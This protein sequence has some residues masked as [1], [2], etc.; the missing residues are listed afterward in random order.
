MKSSPSLLVADKKG[1]I[2]ER[3]GFAL[4]ADR[5]GRLF[6]PSWDEL[7]PLPAESELFYLPGRRATGLNRASGEIEELN[8]TAVAAFAAPGYTL[9]ATPAYA[10]DER[11]PKLPLFAYGAV[12]YGRGKF[13]ICATRV[14]TDKRQVFSNIPA[15]RIEREASRLLKA[16]P[17]NRLVGHI[18]N[19][20]VR[21]YGCPAARNFA[22]G[23]FEAPLPTSRTCDARCVGCISQ[24]Q[25]VG[26]AQTTPQCRIAF[27]PSAKEVAEVMRIH[28][29]R[30]REKPIFSFG[31]G[32][33][34]DPLRNIDLLV[35]SVELYRG[36]GGTGTINC[37]TNASSPEAVARLCDAGLTSM[38]VSLNSSRPEL[39]DAYY[40]PLNYGFDEVRRSLAVARKKSV[41][42]S[43]NLL[44]FPGITDTEEELES[45]A[46]LCSD[47]GVSMIQ[48]RNLN[49]DPIWYRDYLKEFVSPRE[50]M[51]LNSFMA[52]LRERCPWLR[53]GYFNPWLGEKAEIAAP[54]AE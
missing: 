12:G 54:V 7:A 40:R 45:L 33:E 30:E 8:E 25:T 13:W 21:K 44:Y 53:Y 49:I 35:E 23:R 34:G 9:S 52:A 15:G 46:N 50:A 19:N 36:A 39:Y 47:T 29:S 18:I 37:N 6:E 32:C 5:G 51:G 48:W 10:Q 14:D 11:A 43:L 41:F 17:R 26:A 4:M 24:V 27:V 2:V 3:R 42:A 28:A 38:R 16:Y 31:Q 1:K 20:C 22:L